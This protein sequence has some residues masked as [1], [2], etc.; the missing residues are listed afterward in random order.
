MLASNEKKK[1]NERRTNNSVCS[2]AHDYKY[3]WFNVFVRACAFSKYRRM[4]RSACVSLAYESAY[5]YFVP[6][7]FNCNL[8]V[9]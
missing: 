5:G 3:I 7:L 8:V 9:R 2:L 1:K 4:D 6:L